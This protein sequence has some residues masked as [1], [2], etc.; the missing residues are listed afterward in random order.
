MK[1]IYLIFFIL[2]NICVFSMPKSVSFNEG[3]KIGIKDK[4]PVIVFVSSDYCKW[5]SKMKEETFSNKDV[6][7]AMEGF[8]FVIVNIDNS[9]QS[10]EYEGK[11]LSLPDF[12]GFFG[13]RGTPTTIFFDSKG[14]LITVLPGFVQ[15]DIYIKILEYIKLA[16]YEK[17]ISFKDFSSS[18]KKCVKR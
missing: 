2:F 18:P 1:N 9:F 17:N 11:K 8:V 16:C 5:C 7:K 13:V 4:K 15:P 10:F 6:I 3:I 14:M 12:M